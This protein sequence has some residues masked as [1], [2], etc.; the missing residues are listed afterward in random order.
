MNKIFI[1]HIA[2]MIFDPKNAQQMI[3]NS[4]NDNQQINN[5]NAR[6]SVSGR[7]KQKIEVHNVQTRMINLSPIIKYEKN[8]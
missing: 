5:D 1:N 4:I 2:Q 8:K 7:Q 6:V 3:E